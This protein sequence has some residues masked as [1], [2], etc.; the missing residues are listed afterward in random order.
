MRA[1]GPRS[2]SQPRYAAHAVT[3]GAVSARSPPKKPIKNANKSVIMQSSPRP[4]IYS[5]LVSVTPPVLA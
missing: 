3:A 5:P 1:S 4:S 2:F